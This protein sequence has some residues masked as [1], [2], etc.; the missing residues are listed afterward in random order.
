MRTATH[1]A[2]TLQRVFI[3]S[4]TQTKKNA[5]V[6]GTRGVLVRQDGPTAM[7]PK[8]VEVVTFVDTDAAVLQRYQLEVD[9]GML[10]QT[11]TPRTLEDLR[12]E[13]VDVI[14]S[15]FVKTYV[16]VAQSLCKHQSSYAHECERARS[17]Q[18]T[19]T[20]A[21][22]LNLPSSCSV[23]HS[24]VLDGLNHGGKLRMAVRTAIN[25]TWKLAF[26]KPGINDN[27][28]ATQAAWV[29][30]VLRAVLASEKAGSTVEL[31]KSREWVDNMQQLMTL[32][33]DQLEF[34]RVHVRY[35][36]DHAPTAG[37]GTDTDAD[38][39]AQ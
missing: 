5:I 24:P 19:L 14:M 36:G 35:A 33:A 9:A 3:C 17:A 1:V 21:S 29:L 6:K 25:T 39:E 12:K 11:G 38:A 13:P 34:P 7:R 26:S 18:C 8:S 32:C 2:V 37:Y 22:P 4:T 10:T 20:P 31:T 16:A 15:L 30:L 27:L 23:E 28:C